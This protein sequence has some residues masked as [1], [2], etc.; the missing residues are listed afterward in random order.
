MTSASQNTGPP[1]NIAPFM[2]AAALA[3]PL[4]ITILGALTTI[5][6]HHHLTT[7]NAPR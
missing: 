7:T 3:I 1:P 2:M 6:I 5:A 4:T